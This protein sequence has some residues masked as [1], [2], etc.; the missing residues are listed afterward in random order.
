MEKYAQYIDTPIRVLL[1]HIGITRAERF[2]K[3]DCA[4]IWKDINIFF[5]YFPKHKFDISKED[6]QQ[7]QLEI[8]KQIKIHEAASIQEKEH[9]THIQSNDSLAFGILNENSLFNE[10]NTTPLE[11]SLEKRTSYPSQT[12]EGMPID[13]ENKFTLCQIENASQQNQGK[14]LKHGRQHAIRAKRPIWTYFM[15]V[16]TVFAFLIIASLF[17]L[18][19]IAYFSLITADELFSAVIISLIYLGIYSIFSRFTNCEI[20]L[21][22]TFTLGKFTYS[23]YA[24]NYLFLGIP[25]S[26]ALHIIFTT[27]Y[28]CPACGSAKKLFKPNS[29]K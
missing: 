10:R 21:C 24:H 7:A 15:A 20:C 25:L 28:R 29:K 9:N 19:I 23:K 4:D 14:T 11:R 27:W 17:L 8:I 26:T 1:E 13:S 18:P 2:A 16:A 22:H 5:A 6:I 12:P 3:K